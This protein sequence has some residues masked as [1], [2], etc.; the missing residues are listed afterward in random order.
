MMIDRS[1]RCIRG[2]R[3]QAILD[4]AREL[5]SKEGYAATSMSHIAAQLGGSKGTLYNYFRS[6]EELF[7]AHVKERCQNFA[8]SISVPALEGDNPVIV[9]TALAERMLTMLLSEESMGFYRLVIAEAPRNP[10]VGQALH[11]NGPNSKTSLIT[12]LLERLRSEGQ[13]VTDDCFRAS[14]EF[15]S[16]IH[17]GIPL[18][19]LLNIIP[20]PTAAE[21]RDE[22]AKVTE[23]FLRAYGARS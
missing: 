5:F 15:F 2:G 23:T 4:V 8:E 1:E 21:I 9:L 6:K 20:N 10:A 11:K 7:E 13:I 18:K 16:L 12:Q 3:R 19:R 14:E 17:G 22:A